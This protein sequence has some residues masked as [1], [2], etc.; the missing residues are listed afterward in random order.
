MTGEAPRGVIVN[1]LFFL[2]RSD[3]LGHERV[4]PIA[5][6][7]DGLPTNRSLCCGRMFGVS[8]SVLLIGGR[9]ELFEDELTFKDFDV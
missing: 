3:G 6:C 4:L 7:V 1:F 9:D 5:V 8:V 2:I